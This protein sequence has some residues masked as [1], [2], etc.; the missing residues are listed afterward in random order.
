MVFP[1][2]QGQP[3]FSDVVQQASPLYYIL[4]FTGKLMVNIEVL[5]HPPK[6]KNGMCSH[7]AIGNFL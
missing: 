3:H 6:N 2:D 4:I 1:V 5:D 7:Q